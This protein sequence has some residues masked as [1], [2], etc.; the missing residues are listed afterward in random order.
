[1]PATLPA[2]TADDLEDKYVKVEDRCTR[3]NVPGILAAGDLV[4]RICRQAITV[5][6]SGCRAA[7][8]AEWYP[9]DSPSV[10]TPDVP[11][12]VGNLVE[13]Q[14]APATSARERG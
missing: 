14:S 10:P 4:D 7:L 1:M 6:G 5:A 9:R 13:A 11:E 8:D 3:T 12:G 2:F